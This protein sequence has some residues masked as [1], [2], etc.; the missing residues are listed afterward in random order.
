MLIK[1]FVTVVRPTLEYHNS[2]WELLFVLDQGKLKRFSVELATR[3]L[4]PIRDK[5]YGV[6]LLILILQLPSL[7][8]RHIRGDIIL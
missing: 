4:S 6:R 2:V 5:P 1:L 3:L 7:C 8:Y